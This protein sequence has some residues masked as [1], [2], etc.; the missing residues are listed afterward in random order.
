M[1]FGSRYHMQTLVF[2]ASLRNYF[3]ISGHYSTKLVSKD[4]ALPG[5]EEVIYDFIMYSIWNR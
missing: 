3:V 1:T 4:D 2:L 5:R